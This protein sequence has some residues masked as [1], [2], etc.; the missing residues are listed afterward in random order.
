MMMRKRCRN[1]NTKKYGNNNIYQKKKLK[2]K[3]IGDQIFET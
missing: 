3:Y 2:E 1:E